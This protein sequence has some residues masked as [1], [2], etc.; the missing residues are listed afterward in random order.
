MDEFTIAHIDTHMIETTIDLEENQIT[1]DQVL[2][3]NAS[4]FMDLGAGI[5]G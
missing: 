3:G 2:F 4:A 1:F 5:T